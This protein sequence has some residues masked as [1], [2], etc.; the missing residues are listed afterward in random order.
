M[1]LECRSLDA[2]V[3]GDYGGGGDLVWGD[4]HRMERNGKDGFITQSASKCGTKRDSPL[5]FINYIVC[6][7]Y[8]G[9]ISSG[10]LLYRI[11]ES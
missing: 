6:M 8:T 1:F 5:H 9:Q 3:G 2:F 4:L 11:L 7:Q 10:S